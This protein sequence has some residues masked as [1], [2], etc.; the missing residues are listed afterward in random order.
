MNLNSYKTG[1]RLVLDMN[2]HS[3]PVVLIN[4]KTSRNKKTINVMRLIFQSK[5]IQDL[6]QVNINLLR[7]SYE[8]EM[9]LLTWA[10]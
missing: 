4:E 5:H 1:Q 6:D 2:T 3:Y 7:E 9:K 10:K 8:E